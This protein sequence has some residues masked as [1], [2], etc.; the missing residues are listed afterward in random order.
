MGSVT[1]AQFR[2]LDATT[3]FYREQNNEDP[4]VVLKAV[5]FI[6]F[7]HRKLLESA[8]EVLDQAEAQ[9]RSIQQ[10]QCEFSERVFWRVPGSGDKNYTCFAQYCSCPSFSNQAKKTSERILCK[11][12]LAL[13]VDI[14]TRRLEKQEMI[15]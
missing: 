6:L 5:G 1:N 7:D 4:S 13:Q 9:K 3:R 15:A 8:L 11:H 14:S 12:L 10:F 2:L